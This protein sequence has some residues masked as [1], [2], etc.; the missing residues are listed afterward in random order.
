MEYVSE[1]KEK[2]IKTIEN[3]LDIYTKIRNSEELTL[4]EYKKINFNISK[5]SF[6]VEKFTYKKARQ[7]LMKIKEWENVFEELEFKTYLMYYDCEY[8]GDYI[9][10]GEDNM[11][12]WKTEIDICIYKDEKERGFKLG[13]EANGYHSGFENMEKNKDKCSIIFYIGE[14]EVENIIKCKGYD[15]NAEKD[16]VKIVEKLCKLIKQNDLDDYPEY[17]CVYKKVSELGKKILKIIIKKYI[18]LI[19]HNS[20]YYYEED[21]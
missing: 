1:H 5:N 20:S 14:L 2:R 16:T 21:N 6:D 13:V 9:L 17:F 11:I 12:S 15:L 10:P 3:I 19:I 8:D 4:E 18:K 7:E